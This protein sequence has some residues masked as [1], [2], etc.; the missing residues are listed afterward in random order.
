[1]AITLHTHLRCQRAGDCHATEVA[2][3]ERLAAA[4]T[5]ILKAQQKTKQN[6]TKPQT[7]TV[8]TR[9]TSLLTGCSVGSSRIN[10]AA[11]MGMTAVKSL[12]PEQT[13][14]EDKRGWCDGEAHPPES[15]TESCTYGLCDGRRLIPCIPQYVTHEDTGSC[16]RMTQWRGALSRK[17]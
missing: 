17:D 1:M 11:T 4:T 2:R 13:D 8:P 14:R 5:A 9:D 7:Q 16:W 3:R 15:P 10:P 6:Q 12:L